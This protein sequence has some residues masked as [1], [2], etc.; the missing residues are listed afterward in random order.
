MGEEIR[1][2]GTFHHVDG[3]FVSIDANRRN[4]NKGL[5]ISIPF[6]QI[7]NYYPLKTHSV[8]N[9]GGLL[10]GITLKSGETYPAPD[11]KR[12]ILEATHDRVIFVEI[13][14]YSKPGLYIQ[15]P[16]GFHQDWLDF[17]RLNSAKSLEATRVL[18]EWEVQ[19]LVGVVAGTSW[20][21]LALVIGVDVF[22]EAITKK[23][24]KA[25]K[26]A[27]RTLQVL[28]KTK[29]E[30]KQ[31]APTLESVLSDLVWMSLLKGQANYLAPTMLNDP[32]IAARAAGTIVTQ[33]S[34]Q[35]LDQRLTI[36]SF[37]WSILTQV[38]TKAALT[39]PAAL[40]KTVESFSPS[41]PAAAVEKIQE[42]FSSL[43]IVLSDSEKKAIIKE[44]S[45]NPDKIRKIFLRMNQEMKAPPN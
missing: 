18:A 31:V 2:I 33:I 38:G 11:A 41:S 40:S 43:N 30:L 3:K 32:K 1:I 29:R 36:S 26:D 44:L 35:A 17:I 19:F 34:T 21:G 12:V 8:F 9:I 6:D 42:M 10:N 13:K 24:S 37:I 4:F 14:K 27:V 45:D 28:F 5:A 20:K 23:K 15:T 16:S 7:K 39:V 25:T 22:E